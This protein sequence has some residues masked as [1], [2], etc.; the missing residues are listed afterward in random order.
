MDDGGAD[1]GAELLLRAVQDV[2]HGAA[3]VRAAL[4]AIE[5]LARVHEAVGRIGVEQVG[6]G[7]EPELVHVVQD[8]APQRHRLQ[9]V[10]ELVRVRV[11]QACTAAAG[12]DGQREALVER[13][14]PEVALQQLDH[15]DHRVAVVKQVAVAVAD[16]QDARARVLVA[17]QGMRVIRSSESGSVHQMNRKQHL[18]LLRAEQT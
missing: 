14:R 7:H 6:L 12:H 10:L 13:V 3:D 17:A 2:G 16:R 1:P 18:N 11:R 8:V 5:A 15:L 9:H 4:Q